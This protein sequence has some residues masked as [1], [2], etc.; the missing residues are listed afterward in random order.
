M[1]TTTIKLPTQRELL[2]EKYVAPEEARLL[3]DHGHYLAATGKTAASVVAF[4]RAAAIAPEHPMLLASLGAVLFDAGLFLEAEGHLRKSVGIE[5]MYSPAHGNLASVL[6]AQ[7]RYEEAKVEFRT[8]LKIEP[9]FTDAR[10]NFSMCL[11]DSGEWTSEAW[12]YYE[13][14]KERGGKRLYPQLPY[15]E[16]RGEDLNGKTLYVQGEQ[17]IGD[18]TLFSRYLHWVK[19]EFPDA[20]ILFMHNAEDLANIS[21]FMWGYRDIVEFVPNGVPW[22]EDVDYGIYLM[23]LPGMHGTTPSNVYDDPGLLLKNAE[24]HKNSV[25]L[26]VTDDRMMKVGICWSGNP[27]MK[28]NAERSIPL[29]LMLSLAELPDV[30]LF[31]LQIGTHDIERVGADQLV[32]DLTPDISPLGFTGTAAVMQ[33]LDL[34]ITC[35][36]A[37]AHVAGALGVPCW[38]LLCKNPYWLWLRDTSRSVWYENTVL[39]RQQSM[40]DWSPVIA[41]VRSELARCAAEHAACRRQKV[42]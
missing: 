16:W 39:F 4:R 7:G 8:A 12:S 2:Q 34:V 38:T 29:E 13:A 20:R 3:N 18:R 31:G 21:N 41:E 17:G 26:P 22:P 10:W 19:T 30:V 5:P 9:D 14:R 23:S 32:C 42:A 15:P 6:G 28:R 24:R 11:L 1:T 37:N 36:T 25:A 33:N 27:K 40:N 35:C